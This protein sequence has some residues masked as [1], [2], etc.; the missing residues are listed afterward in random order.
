[1][2]SSRDVYGLSIVEVDPMQGMEESTVDWFINAAPSMARQLDK[3]GIRNS[4][5][6][7]DLALLYGSGADVNGG[8][9]SM[10]GTGRLSIEVVGWPFITAFVGGDDVEVET[11]MVGEVEEKDWE[12]ETCGGQCTFEVGVGSAE[13][14]SPRGRSVDSADWSPGVGVDVILQSG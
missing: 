10:D 12:V 2:E 11:D 3:D 4:S 6:D 8:V 7:V 5:E 13:G 1:M 9:A 14:R